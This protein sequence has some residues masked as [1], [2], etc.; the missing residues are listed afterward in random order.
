[1]AEVQ[2]SPCIVAHP[3]TNSMVSIRL[4]D[5]Q[6]HPGVDIVEDTVDPNETF[7]TRSASIA[8]KT[9]SSS[10]NSR[11]EAMSLESVDWEGLEKEEQERCED[12]TDEVGEQYSRQHTIANIYRLPHYSLRSLNR[13]MQPLSTIPRP[14]SKADLAA[15]PDLPPCNSS[16]SLSVAHKDNLCDTHYYPHLQ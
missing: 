10:S 3:A 16:R 2:A 14:I 1:M 12:S 7:S 6:I 11:D 13:P 9:S 8:T 15:V 5:V 4:S